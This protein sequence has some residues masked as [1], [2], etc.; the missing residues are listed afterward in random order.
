MVITL[1]LTISAD[2]DPV[3]L[4]LDPLNGGVGPQL[5]AQRL[6]PEGG[7]QHGQLG[8]QI[9]SFPVKDDDV[10]LMERV[11]RPAVARLLDRNERGVDP[12]LV[13]GGH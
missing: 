6:G 5:G 7:L 13:D 8:A 1:A 9:A 11:L 2:P 3:V 12:E 4:G 10:A